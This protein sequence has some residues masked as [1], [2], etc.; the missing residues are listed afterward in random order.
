MLVD[1]QHPLYDNEQ[2]LRAKK[3]ASGGHVRV[4]DA[5]VSKDALTAK[6]AGLT[7][8]KL[9]DDPGQAPIDRRMR[10][11]S[12][13]SRPPTRV[14]ASSDDGSE[15]AAPDAA[16]AATPESMEEMVLR[17]ARECSGA[18]GIRAP[19]REDLFGPALRRGRSEAPR[20]VD[21]ERIPLSSDEVVDD[22]DDD[23]APQI[24]EF[25]LTPPP[26]SS[27]KRKRSPSR[28]PPRAWEAPEGSMR[29]EDAAAA[30]HDAAKRRKDAR[31]ARRLLEGELGD[32]LRSRDPPGAVHALT[33]SDDE[34]TSDEEDDPHALFVY[35][36][37]SL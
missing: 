20:F 34:S 35:S 7:L 27:V 16:P 24:D 12:P 2:S 21:D 37:W 14:S 10:R 9:T 5:A 8:P 26:T 15:A 22:D 29:A 36:L 6:L 13:E 25:F 32:A 30:Y 28:P 17:L 31:K 1:Q 33:K 23:A 11:V 4:K 3:D 19:S 18:A